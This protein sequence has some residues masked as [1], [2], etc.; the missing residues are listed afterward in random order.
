MSVLS[1][2]EIEG[3]IEQK[4]VVCHPLDPSNIRGSSID[5]TLG[6][7]F[8]FCGRARRGG[9]Y[10]PFDRNDTLSYFGKPL[11]AKPLSDPLMRLWYGATPQ[12]GIPDD[13]PVIWLPGRTRILAHTHEFVGIQ[14]P[15]TTEMRARSSWGRNGIAVCLCA[16]WGDP[17]YI[18]RWT[19][20]V[21]NFNDG[22][23]PLP[24][25]ER[26][27]QMIFHRTGP[28]S[29]HYGDDGKYQGGVDLCEIVEG[30]RPEHM[31]PRSYKDKRKPL[32]DIPLSKE[33]IT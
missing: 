6:E 22:P 29:G 20:E 2:I 5:L 21:H 26:I 3:A 1:N 30:W 16:G 9:A 15:G 33:M 10:N 19:M 25:G 4:W 28:V 31:L 8:Y 27:A 24:V 14:P 7:N 13:H 23:V 18:N 32:L 17:G 12:P 11:K